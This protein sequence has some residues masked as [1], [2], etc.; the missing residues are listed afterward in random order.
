MV[1]SSA[2][3]IQ[4]ALATS[5]IKENMKHLLSILF[6]GSVLSLV[7]GGG[8]TEQ[9]TVWGWPDMHTLHDQEIRTWFHLLPKYIQGSLL[10]PP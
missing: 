8:A 10:N 7:P 6:F 5:L 9:E 4:A 3:F 1:S 2:S